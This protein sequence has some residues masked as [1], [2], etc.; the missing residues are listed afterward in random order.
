MKRSIPV[1]E[2]P[3]DALKRLCVAAGGEWLQNERAAGL[4]IRPDGQ[5]IEVQYLFEEETVQVGVNIG[6][7]PMFIMDWEAPADECHISQHPDDGNLLTV[8]SVD[9]LG[10]KSNQRLFWWGPPARYRGGGV[11]LETDTDEDQHLLPE[12]DPDDVGKS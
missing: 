5:S 1:G 12:I 3:I 2:D 9:G 4:T 10:D 6:T 7:G 8:L 11:K